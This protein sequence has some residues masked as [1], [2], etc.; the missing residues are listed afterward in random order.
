[1]DIRRHIMGLLGII[2]L[3]SGVGLLVVK[4]ASDSQW[5]MYASICIRVGLMLS[6]IW[7]AFPQIEGLTKRFPSWLMAT[8]GV[9]AFIIAA[10]PRRIVYLGPIVAAIAF[11]QFAGWLFKPLP[12]PK[13][14]AKAAS[15]DDP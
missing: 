12:N 13:R 14:Q 15:K 1:M 11:L 10:S 3:L 2:F 8:I 7:L 6:A 9:M 5:S 4:G